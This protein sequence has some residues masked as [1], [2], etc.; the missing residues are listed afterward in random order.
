VFVRAAGTK[1][2]ICKLAIIKHLVPD[3]ALIPLHPEK[4]KTNTWVWCK[5]T[6]NTNLCTLSKTSDLNAEVND[7]TVLFRRKLNP[8]T[9]EVLL[10]KDTF[11]LVCAL[12]SRPLVTITYNYEMSQIIVIRKAPDYVSTVTSCCETLHLEVNG[13]DDRQNANVL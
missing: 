13:V 4:S 10:A 12:Y 2:L 5:E 6:M 3:A 11:L 1:H 8:F 9:A 7:L